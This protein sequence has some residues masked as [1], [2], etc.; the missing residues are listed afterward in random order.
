MLFVWYCARSPLLFCMVDLQHTQSHTAHSSGQQARRWV[1]ACSNV[2]ARLSFVTLRC[3]PVCPCRRS[4]SHPVLSLSLGAA[5]RTSPF[6][7]S[8]ASGV[9]GTPALA[10]SFIGRDTSATARP[11]PRINRLP[12]GLRTQHALLLVTASSAVC[13]RALAE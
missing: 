9:I 5:S 2:S 11:A 13:Y 12:A 10:A 7:F 4:A 3:A 6:L 1:R 8:R